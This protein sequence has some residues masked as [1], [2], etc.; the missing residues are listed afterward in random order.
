ME[1]KEGEL[2]TNTYTEKMVAGPWPHASRSSWE[3]PTMQLDILDT[4]KDDEMH[5]EETR[6]NKKE[7]Q[8][9]EDQTFEAMNREVNIMEA[10]ISYG[11]DSSSDRCPRW[12]AWNPNKG[13]YTETD[14]ENMV[15]CPWPYTSKSS[16][17]MPTMQLDILETIKEDEMNEEEKKDKDK[18]DQGFEDHTF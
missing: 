8:D 7:D 17:E 1:F 13:N 16:W 11:S 12:D 2:C 6:D 4:I 18:E 5:E 14:T 15:A 3:M 9:F 10:Q